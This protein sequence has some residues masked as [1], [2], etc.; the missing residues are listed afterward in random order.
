MEKTQLEV[1]HKR[2]LIHC[3][4]MSVESLALTS[5]FETCCEGLKNANDILLQDIFR[6]KWGCLFLFKSMGFI[7]CH[8]F[9]QYP[10]P[11]EIVARKNRQQKIF[12]ISLQLVRNL[13][14]SRKTTTE[15]NMQ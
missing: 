10:H 14:M 2:A 3:P 1:G 15:E 13:S 4:L 8:H 7:I 6:T 12:L 5:P 9:S 11:Y